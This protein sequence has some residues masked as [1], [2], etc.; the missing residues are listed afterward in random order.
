VA[1]EALEAGI[2]LWPNEPEWHAWA[3]ELAVKAGIYYADVDHW[4]QAALLDATNVDYALKLTRA[5]LAKNEPLDAIDAL[6]QPQYLET[7]N[8]EVW[9][10][11][12]EAS[13]AAGYF[14]EAL[15]YAEL[16]QNWTPRPNQCCAAARSPCRWKALMRR[17]NMLR[18]HFSAIHAHRMWCCSMPKSCSSAVSWTLPWMSFSGRCRVCRTACRF[19]WNVRD[20]CAS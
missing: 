3:A 2:S 20:W 19:C 1:M 8:P 6:N 16:V 5:H 12:A 7:E 17:S 18:W 13:Q 9:L 11:L 14:K 10:T 4:R 15:Q